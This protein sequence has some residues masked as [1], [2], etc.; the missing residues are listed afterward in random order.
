MLDAD[1]VST[2]REAPTRRLSTVCLAARIHVRALGRIDPR[3]GRDGAALC[4]EPLGV[5]RTGNR[6]HRGGARACVGVNVACGWRQRRRRQPLRIHAGSQEDWQQLRRHGAGADALASRRACLQREFARAV[7]GA[8]VHILVGADAQYGVRLHVHAKRDV[9]A[10]RACRLEGIL[11]GTG[12]VAHA[13]VT[14]V[15]QPA[16]LA[17]GRAGPASHGLGHLRATGVAPVGRRR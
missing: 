15:V 7:V 1:A 9:S 17:V 4:R 5:R 16:L 14:V 8:H 12:L 11:H 2:W 6:N 3:S 10:H 13:V